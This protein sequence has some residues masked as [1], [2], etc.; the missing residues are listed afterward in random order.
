[1]TPQKGAYGS[2]PARAIAWVIDVVP[3]VVMWTL[4]EAVALGTAGQECSASEGGGLSCSATSSRVADMLL[5]AVVVLTVGY[6]VWNFGA[7]QGT[8]GSSLGKSAMRI[9]VVAERTWEPVGFGRSLFRQALHVIDAAPCFAGYLLPLVDTRR[10]TLADKMMST[11][12]V[13][14]DPRRTGDEQGY[15]G[16]P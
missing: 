9:R 13:P 3:V 14:L 7:R 16:R 12:C 5:G 10:Q 15:P 1:M 4:W 6:L 11:V 2:W 8:R